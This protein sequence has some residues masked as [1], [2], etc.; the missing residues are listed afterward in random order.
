MFQDCMLLGF[1]AVLEIGSAMAVENNFIDFPQLIF[2]VCSCCCRTF[3]SRRASTSAATASQ[4]RERECRAIS[5]RFH[6][7][8]SARSSPTAIDSTVRSTNIPSSGELIISGIPPAR[9]ARTGVPQASAYETTLG[10]PSR[11]L[12][13]QL[14]SAALNH[15]FN[16]SFGLFPKRKMRSCIFFPRTNCSSVER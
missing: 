15:R 13:R 5:A 11:E 16:S 12:I 10:Q 8:V 1:S 6:G 2:E 14:R 4:L 3:D 7:L 9:V